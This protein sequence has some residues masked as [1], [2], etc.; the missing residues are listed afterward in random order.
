MRARHYIASVLLAALM[1]AAA[2]PLAAQSLPHLPKPGRE[3]H[4]RQRELREQVARMA[5]RLAQKPAVVCGTTVIPADPR[6]DRKAIKP[7]P[8]TGPK[9]TIRQVPAPACR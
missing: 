2:I 3:L 8:D 7:V 9:S 1:L 6:L 4:A 5:L